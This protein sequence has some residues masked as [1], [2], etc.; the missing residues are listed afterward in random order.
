MAICDMSG[1]TDCTKED[2]W[3]KNVKGCAFTKMTI[4]IE[5]AKGP[6]TGWL[7][8]MLADF[9]DYSF[10]FYDKNKEFKTS[11][12]NAHIFGVFKSHSMERFLLEI[13]RNSKEE[14]LIADKERRRIAK[15]KFV[16]DPGVRSNAVYALILNEVTK[17]FLDQNG[18]LK[19]AK[20]MDTL[21]Q[22]ILQDAADMI[23]IIES[24]E[25]DNN[26]TIGKLM[27]SGSLSSKSS[28]K[29]VG[30]IKE[31]AIK[32]S[33]EEKTKTK[34]LSAEDKNKT[35]PDKKTK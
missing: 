32:L 35:T 24:K 25:Q 14:A 22:Q 4:C 33:E 3:K 18:Y 2:S 10:Y 17:R 12:D 26:G 23:A 1:K 5:Q 31:K 27:G 19:D 29:L 21:L 9:W 13:D 34:T 20:F 15:K 28:A 6:K 11:V 30:L 16:N 7:S 8:K